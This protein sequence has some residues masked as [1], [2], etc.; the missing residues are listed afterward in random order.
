MLWFAAAS[1]LAFRFGNQ[2]LAYHNRMSQSRIIARCE[3]YTDNFH[4][5]TDIEM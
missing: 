2:P 1:R 5:V 4:S 3:G